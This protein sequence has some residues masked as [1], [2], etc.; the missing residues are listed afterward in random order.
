MT[1]HS[2]PHNLLIPLEYI[3]VTYLT[4]NELKILYNFLQWQHLPYDNQELQDLVKKIR[5]II[6]ES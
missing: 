5:K 6:N 3:P 4:I 2:D 1:S